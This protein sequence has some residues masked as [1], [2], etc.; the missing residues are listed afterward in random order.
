[1]GKDLVAGGRYV[2]HK[3]RTNPE[4]D[5]V[6]LTLLVQLYRFLARRTGSKFN[7]VVLKRLYMSKTNRP[8]LSISRIAKLMAGQ[9][10]KVA[11]LVGTVTDDV[12]ITELPALTVCALRVTAGARARILKAGGKVMTFD[13][14]ALASP[15]GQ[16]TVLVRGA[17]TA[18]EAQKHF[19]R[20][21]TKERQSRNGLHIKPFVRGHGK[22]RKIESARG[23]RR[24]KGF[25]I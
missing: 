12:R 4:S 11:V 7:A 19:G 5:N 6:Y 20:P 21:G 1:M 17:K 15:T 8:P 2:G 16:N 9:E 24:S 22:N 13:Q 25:K 18:R 14:L 10:S 3:N 23:K